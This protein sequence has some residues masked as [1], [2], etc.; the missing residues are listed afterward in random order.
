MTVPPAAGP[1]R[2]PTRSV[3]SI[4]ADGPV[5]LRRQLAVQLAGA[6][7]EGRWSVGQRLPSARALSSRLEIHR[8]TVRAAYAELA[9]RGLVEVRPGSGAYVAGGDAGA[10][11]SLRGFLARERAA[12]RSVEEVAGLLD[13]WSESAAARRVVVVGRDPEL[14][15]VWA[16]EVRQALSTAA[17]EVESLVLSRV[18]AE[19]SRLGR[20]LVAAGPASRA[21]TAALAPPWTEVVALRPGPSRRTRR[22]LLRVPRGTVLATVSRSRRLVEELR[23]LAAGLRGGAVAVAAAGLEEGRRL[24]RLVGVARFVL[25]DVTCREALTDLVPGERRLTLRHLAPG[26]LALLVR[27]LGEPRAAD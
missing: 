17:V 9:G 10:G 24:R 19:P 7:R 5:S 25:V 16:A 23:A 6:V 12:G 27:Y 13:R 3:L 26:D 1:P 18:R 11:R 22:L 14:L 8:E 4:H 20:G 15:A 21:E 2:S